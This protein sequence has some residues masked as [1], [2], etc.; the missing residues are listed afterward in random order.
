MPQFQKDIDKLEHV[1]R[2]VTRMVEELESMTYGERLRE[3]GMCSLQ[4]RRARGDRIAVF[5]YVKGNHVEEGANLFTA[6]L[7]TRTRSNG[8]KLQESR[9]HLNSRKHFLTV[10][11]VR[12]WNKLPSRVVESPLL[13]VFRRRLDEHLSGES[14][15]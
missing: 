14:D 2:R 5:N 1:Q 13:E 12:R 10:R 6:A 15:F 4:Q 11:A 3:L 9:F 8:F 7:E